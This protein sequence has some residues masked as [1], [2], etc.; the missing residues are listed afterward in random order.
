M[1]NIW[2]LILFTFRCAGRAVVAILLPLGL[3]IITH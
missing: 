2:C 1:L 3:S